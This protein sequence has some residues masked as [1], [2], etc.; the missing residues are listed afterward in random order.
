MLGEMD[1]CDGRGEVGVDCGMG[2]EVADWGD[3][4]AVTGEYG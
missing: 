3:S 1:G 4:E 2:A